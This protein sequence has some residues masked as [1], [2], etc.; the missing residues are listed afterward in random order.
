MLNKII[1]IKD[2]ALNYAYGFKKNRISPDDLKSVGIYNIKKNENI[3]YFIVS[4]FFIDY[5]LNSTTNHK[6]I[7]KS[8]C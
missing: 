4:Y 6:F 8:Y 5:C 1:S 7:I 2:Y 3:L